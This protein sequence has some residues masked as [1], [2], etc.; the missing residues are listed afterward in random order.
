MFLNTY[1]HR[2]TFYI[3]YLIFLCPCLGLDPFMLYICDLFSASFSLSLITDRLVFYIFFRISLTI[4]GA[5]GYFPYRPDM[6]CRANAQMLKVCMSKYLFIL[7]ILVLR[8]KFQLPTQQSF[9]LPLQL[10]KNVEV[11]VHYLKNPEK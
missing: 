2:Y 10:D 9:C 6:N 8:T 11:F 3:L 5:Y 7:Y 1:N 4:L